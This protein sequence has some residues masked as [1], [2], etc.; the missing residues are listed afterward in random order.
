MYNSVLLY[1][2]RDNPEASAGT[3]VGNNSFLIEGT[4]PTQLGVPGKRARVI[5]SSVAT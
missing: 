5:I 4:F 1:L 3:S 2:F